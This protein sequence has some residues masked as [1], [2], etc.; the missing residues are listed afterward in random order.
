MGNQ[1]QWD[2]QLLAALTALKN[3]D[4]SVRLPTG[5]GGTA[6][7]IAETYNATVKQCDALL[8]EATRIV[9]EVGPIGKYGGQAHMEGLSGRWAAFRDEVNKM[10]VV[11]TCYIRDA[12][13][14]LDGLAKG[15][16]TEPMG[17]SA[18][19]ELLGL[20]ESVNQLVARHGTAPTAN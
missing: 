1:P 10:G 8:V 7:Q 19:D 5:Q 9:R 3:G 20:K 12:A 14:T 13:R 17:F 16:P 6:D 15:Q 4:F 18:E 11:L 2:S